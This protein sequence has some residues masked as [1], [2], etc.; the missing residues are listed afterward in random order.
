MHVALSVV[1][2]IPIVLVQN[3][4]KHVVSKLCTYFKRFIGRFV[5]TSSTHSAAIHTYSY[6]FQ[7]K[8]IKTSKQVQCTASIYLLCIF[9]ISIFG[10]YIGKGTLWTPQYVGDEVNETLKILDPKV[11]SI[12]RNAI[13]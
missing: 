1:R 13:T 5:I 11:K 4:L 12:N 6:A 8:I 9:Y 7:R 10:S 3:S 2:Y